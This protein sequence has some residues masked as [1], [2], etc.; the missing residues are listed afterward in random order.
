MEEHAGLA[1]IVSGQKAIA[2]GHPLWHEAGG[3]AQPT[4]LA[5]IDSL[6]A[7][8]GADL[9]VRLADVR[10]FGIRPSHYLLRMLP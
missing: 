3:L 2:L 7:A 6:R 8:H 9:D 4:Q 10:D 1:C 5:A